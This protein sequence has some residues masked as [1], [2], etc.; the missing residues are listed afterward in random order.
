MDSGPTGVQEKAPMSA[1]STGG[2]SLDTLLPV[3][4]TR[5]VDEV[6]IA[7]PRAAVWAAFEQLKTSDMPVANVLGTIRAIPLAARQWLSRPAREAQ[8]AAPAEQTFGELM[9]SGESW[10]LLA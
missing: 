6:T 7:R 1:P 4:E 2:V 5:M 8:P 3:Y 10:V 9:L